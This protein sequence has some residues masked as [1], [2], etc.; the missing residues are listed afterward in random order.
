[1]RTLKTAILVALLLIVIINKCDAIN[2]KHTHLTDI[3]TPILTLQKEL[4]TARRTKKWDNHLKYT[5]KL[6]K[7]YRD[8]SDYV[9]AHKIYTTSANLYKKISQTENE[10]ILYDW[11]FEIYEPIGDS[12]RALRDI[13][14]AILLSKNSK[15]DAW[16]A[17]HYNN[18]GRFYMMYKKY[19]AALVYLDSSLVL[20]STLRNI[21]RMGINE[22]NKGDCYVQ[23]KEYNQ[24]KKNFNRAITH[25]TTT[26]FFIGLG[27][28]YSS[29]LEVFTNQREKA[30]AKRCAIKAMYWADKAK[31][32]CVFEQL[33]PALSAYYTLVQKPDSSSYYQKEHTDLMDSIYNIRT[34]KQIT[35]QEMK[36]KEEELNFWIN[37]NT[38]AEK[39]MIE[40]QNS[41]RDALYWFTTLAT[42]LAFIFFLL[43]IKRNARKKKDEAV[44]DKTEESPPK[45]LV[46]EE[47]DI[48]L[49][50]ALRAL[51]Q[52]EKLFLNEKFSLND[53]ANKLN[54][55]KTYLSKAI[56]SVHKKR[57]STLINEY[58]IEESMKLLS[59]E[60]FNYLSIEG[61]ASAVGFSS[62]SSFNRTFKDYVGVTPSEFKMSK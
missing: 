41:G 52:T 62:K 11:A 47:Q 50:E 40:S 61:I 36:A 43:L 30:E 13:R 15:D 20:N 55:N 26:S 57:F 49:A 27:F 51:M 18:M 25:F 59:A 37:K 2:Q 32:H 44:E 10:K 48:S 3:N 6:I 38:T 46:P 21:N 31:Y 33:Y 34:V 45:D 9:N 56:N 17:E 1:M 42:A 7:Y 54:T 8:Q 60:E 58:R 23:L 35:R 24:S 16:L 39:R 14:R 29:L 53:A 28:T 5:M 22:L 12:L 19:K 4:E